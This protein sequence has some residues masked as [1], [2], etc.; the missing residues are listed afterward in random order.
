MSGQEVVYQ[1]LFNARTL[2][3]SAPTEP[4]YR[5]WVEHVPTDWWG[6]GSTVFIQT[7]ALFSSYCLLFRKQLSSELGKCLL[8]V[9]DQLLGRCLTL[10]EV[11]TTWSRICSLCP[12]G[13]SRTDEWAWCKGRINARTRLSSPAALLLLE[14]PAERAKYCWA[15]RFP[16]WQ[17]QTTLKILHFNQQQGV[18]A[19]DGKSPRALLALLLP[20]TAPGHQAQWALVLT[21]PSPSCLVPLVAEVNSAKNQMSYSSWHRGMIIPPCSVCIWP[22]NHQR[23]K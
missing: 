6:Q 23:I 17:L 7:A 10:T 21:D 20:P 14:Y 15:A 11:H 4:V 18:T 12:W 9:F 1:G 2:C 16:P 19:M 13:S 8:L 22:L 5:A 3:Q